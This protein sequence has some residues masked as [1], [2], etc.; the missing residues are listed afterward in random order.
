MYSWKTLSAIAAILLMIPVIHLAYIMSRD[1]LLVLNG[2][3]EAWASEVEAYSRLDSQGQLPENPVVVVGGRR[4]SLWK[5]LEDLLA[6]KAVLN[7]SL[8]D[9]TTT[10]ITH[11]YKLLIG[12][13]RPETVILLPGESEFHIRDSKSADEFVAAVKTLAELDLSHGITRHFY[14]F[15]PLKTPLYSSNNPKID[16]ITS[17]LQKW[18]AQIEEVHILDA[19]TLLT[20]RNGGAKPDYFRSD[21]VNLNEPGYLRISMLLLNQMEQDYPEFY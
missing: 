21:G 4:V 1:T 2:S 19:N 15:V 16:E 6:P 14:I 8:G 20:D 9:A 11:F 10:D 17:R 5:G 7:R 18:A 3:P 13:Y 12:F